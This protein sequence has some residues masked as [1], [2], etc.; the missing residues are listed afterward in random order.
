MFQVVCSTASVE[1]DTGCT[2]FN[3]NV[4][5]NVQSQNDTCRSVGVV[6]VWGPDGVYI[7]RGRMAYTPSRISRLC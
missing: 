3:V 6:P 2:V 1:V 4:D 7:G 5:A